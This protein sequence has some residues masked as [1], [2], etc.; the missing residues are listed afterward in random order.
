MGVPGVLVELRRRRVFRTAALYIV[1]AWVLIQV[2]DLALESWGFPAEALRYVWI[3]TVLAFPLALVFGWYFDVTA[4][5]VV[6][7]PGD[8]QPTDLSLR[9][10]DFLI[11]GVLILVIAAVGWGVF[12][13]IRETDVIGASESEALVPVSARSIAVLPFVNLSGTASDEPF[14][15]GIHE[16]ILAQLARIGSLRVISRTSVQQYRDAEKS[17]PDIARELGVASVLEGSVQ[18]A[19]DRV[20]ITVQLIDAEKEKHL[21][22][23]IY[24]QEL[25][26]ENIFGVQSDI[27]IAV[28]VALDAVLTPEDE[29]KI[30]L[31]PTD[32]F[33]AYEAYLLG[34]Q[35]QL[36]RV[37]ESLEKALVHFERAV[38]L[39]SEFALAWVGIADSYMLM[40]YYAGF[41]NVVMRSNALQAIENALA[42]DPELGEAYAILGAVEIRGRNF[43]QAQEAFLTAIDLAPGY[44]P[45]YLWYADLLVNFLGQPEAAL[46]LLERARALNPLYPPVIATLGQ[47]Y[48]GLG[49]FE[50]ATIQYLKT[51]QVAP[52]YASA[53]LLLS[54]MYRF[55][56][57]RLDQAL[58]W[59]HRGV[60]A[61]PGNMLAI[62]TLAI[63]YLDLD[64]P[65]MAEPW[66]DHALDLSDTSIDAQA[67]ALY[68]EMHL[69]RET[70]TL[71]AAGRFWD[72]APFN[73]MSLVVFLRY[74]R[75]EEM[76]RRVDAA[77][78]QICDESFVLPRT[79]VQQSVTVAVALQHTGDDECA[80]RLLNQALALTEE[81]PRLG[82]RGYGIA[83]AS[84]YAAL[85]RN[86]E[87]LDALEAAIDDGWR[88]GWWWRMEYNP[89]M[90]GLRD[91]PRYRALLAGLR[92]D[93]VAQS[94]YLR[95]MLDTQG[96][97]PYPLR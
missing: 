12:K 50:E 24:D 27:A 86:T 92:E 89:V 44:A 76:I 69:G 16:D 75:H 28:A 29:R 57:G 77:A 1:G 59:G 31:I 39:D 40:A 33:Q 37:S 61:D 9:R 35:L 15:N 20:R 78:P 10:S 21:W 82:L 17:V 84:A 83:D 25:T 30:T 43:G 32:N 67:A 79:V 7:T 66:I 47:A 80:A 34:R 70:Q 96:I 87:A 64:E 93:M 6:H 97:D 54:G 51:V 13:Q 4:A 45:A 41:D 63:A 46:P 73:G 48:E 72:V 3:G 8:E 11:L 95:S 90:D 19:E 58:Y 91:D 74:G 88:T 2:A 65:G 42:L 94:Q 85:G 55:R 23:D 5:G 18:R 22:S 53:Y 14:T 52:D 81:M 60:A 49:R 71:E 26:T 38:E 56:F 36:A 68:W 62:V